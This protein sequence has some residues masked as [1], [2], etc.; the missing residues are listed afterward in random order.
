MV[1]MVKGRNFLAE[2]MEGSEENMKKKEEKYR[3]LLESAAPWVASHRREEE[4]DGGMGGN[5]TEDAS[6]DMG[7]NGGHMG[8][9]MAMDGN[10]TRGGNGT[11][12]MMD[13]DSDEEPDENFIHPVYGIFDKEHNCL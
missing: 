13:E 5:A 1:E 9:N 10:M 12:G 6:D 2:A 8:G 7:M 11:G 3:V 4:V